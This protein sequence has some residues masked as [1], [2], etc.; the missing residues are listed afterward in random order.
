MCQQ[1]KTKRYVI[2]IGG[3]VL[4]AIG[5]LLLK[6]A[7][8]SGGIMQILPYCCLGIGC[9]AFGW[10][11]GEALKRHAVK[12]DPELLREIEIEQ[13]DERTV[14]IAN[15]AKARAYDIMSYLYA[16]LII[17]F[18]LMGVDLPVLLML[19]AAFLFIEGV[20]IYQ[21]VKL[22]KKL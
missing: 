16:A 21:M 18:G 7:P 6:Y 5:L 12:N 9:G 20:M 2:T 13:Q 1:S 11:S 3:I 15:A 8:D 10:G 22:N 19:V 17:T 4:I 14:F